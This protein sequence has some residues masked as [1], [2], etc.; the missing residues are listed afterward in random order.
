MQIIFTEKIK[1]NYDLTILGI[2]EENKFSQSTTK[3]DKETKKELM[4]L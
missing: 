3:F 4:S 2:Y 1:N